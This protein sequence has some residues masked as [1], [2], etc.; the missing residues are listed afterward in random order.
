MHNSQ[1]PDINAGIAKT[2]KVIIALGCSFVQG[3]AAIDMEIL[4]EFPSKCDSL[5]VPMDIGSAADAENLLSRFPLLIR[6][7]NGSIDYTFMEYKNAFV[8]ILCSELF[9]GEYTPINLGR[10]GNG[11]RATI[12]DL[13]FYPEINWE[14]VKEYIVIYAPSGLERFDFIDDTFLDHNKW[15]AMWPHYKDVDEPR[16]RLWRGYNDC[17]WSDK[18]EALEQLAHAQ[19]LVQW[20]KLR[21]AK[22]ITVPAFD[23]RYNKTYFTTSLRKLHYRDF[24]RNK[25]SGP[26]GLEIDP[27]RDASRF[28]N[29]FPWETLFRP[30]DCE[31]FADLAVKQEFAD[32][33]DRSFFEFFKTGSPNQW[34]TACAHPSAK[35]HRLLANELYNYIM[36][37][38]DETNT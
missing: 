26:G 29:L 4:E 38:K 32:F 22:L 33:K 17:L 2:G 8:N 19:E 25:I 6:R 16:R 13:Y 24:H 7:N 21:N 37:S 9:A 18:F 20:C 11:N 34:I 23:R 14:K 31:T 35:A 12:K 36:E 10:R 15:I 1:I 5:G 30:Q 28:I 27:E 3:Q